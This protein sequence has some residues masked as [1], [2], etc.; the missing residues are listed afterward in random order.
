MRIE[1]KSAESI[2]SKVWISRLEIRSQ[3]FVGNWW[4]M[5]TKP[6]IYFINPN[7]F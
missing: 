7:L 5:R 3:K 1:N 6:F 2:S 4:S